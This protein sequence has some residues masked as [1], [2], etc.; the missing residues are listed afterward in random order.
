MTNVGA[1]LT[2]LGAAPEALLLVARDTLCV[3]LNFAAGTLHL[4]PEGG[5]GVFE[6]F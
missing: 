3:G 1:G 4:P 6:A 2:K 5:W